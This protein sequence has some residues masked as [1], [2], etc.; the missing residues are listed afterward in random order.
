MAAVPTETLADAGA[1]V[2][3][4]V[5]IPLVMLLPFWSSALVMVTE[6]AA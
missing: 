2:S 3:P 6:L 5:E 1:Q 4:E